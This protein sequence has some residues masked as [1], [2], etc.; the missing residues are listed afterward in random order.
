MN[1]IEKFELTE[2]VLNFVFFT[3]NFTPKF[4]EKCWADNPHLIEH[5]KSK[6]YSKSN[7]GC[8]DMGG[9]MRFF[10]DMDKENMEKLIIWID[11]NY[12]Y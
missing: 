5:L 9:F 2:A 1:K 4:I 11:E 8:I 10:M 7:G 3:A 12:N 6:L